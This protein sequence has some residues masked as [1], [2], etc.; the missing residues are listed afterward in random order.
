M[1]DSSMPS[2]RDVTRA[3][4]HLVAWVAYHSGQKS[5]PSPRPARLTHYGSSSEVT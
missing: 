3:I 4:S 2:R 1:E 5:E